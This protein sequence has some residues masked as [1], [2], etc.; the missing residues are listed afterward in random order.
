[1]NGTRVSGGQEQQKFTEVWSSG[2]WYIEDEMLVMWR[3]RKGLATNYLYS[4][5]SWVKS[6]WSLLHALM[7][8]FLEGQTNLDTKLPYFGSLRVYLVLHS[9]TDYQKTCQHPLSC[10]QWL[11]ISCLVPLSVFISIFPLSPLYYFHQNLHSVVENLYC[12]KS[13]LIFIWH[14]RGS[15]GGK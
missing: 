10:L 1:M 12:T 2:T 4:V 8:Y 7:I 5:I 14:W 13:I 9:M 15:G 6:L 3:G 11:L